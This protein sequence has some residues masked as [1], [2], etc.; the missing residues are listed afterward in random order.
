MPTIVS[1]VM[2]ATAA[3]LQ[4]ALHWCI[5]VVIASM[6]AVRFL[7]ALG[8]EL[9]AKLNMPTKAALLPPSAAL[10]LAAFIFIPDSPP[11]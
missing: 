2:Q 9:L 5:I 6:C 1:V 3:V 8:A 11:A 7:T 4:L 10:C